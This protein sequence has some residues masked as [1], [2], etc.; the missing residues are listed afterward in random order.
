MCGMM[1]FAWSASGEHPWHTLLKQVFPGV[2]ARKMLRM[3][4]L[5]EPLAMARLVAGEE[6]IHA[7]F[8]KD[9]ASVGFR[10]MIPGRAGFKN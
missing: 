6:S 1:F 2:A 3:I 7:I 4:L 10:S 9:T 5:R 8:R